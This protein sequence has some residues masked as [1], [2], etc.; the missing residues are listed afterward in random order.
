[1]Y[2]VAI[3]PTGLHCAVGFTDKLRVYHIL[4]DDLR[5]C[6][7]VPIKG[8]RDCRFHNGGHLLAAA[9]GNSIC[10]YDFYSGEKIADLRGHNSKV[11]GLCLFL[12]VLCWVVFCVVL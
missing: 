12:F 8:C 7:E 2:S 3:H 4:V 9:N 5:I 1:M 10:I 6:M 11:N